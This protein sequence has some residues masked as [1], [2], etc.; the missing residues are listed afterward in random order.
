MPLRAPISKIVRVVYSQA[1]AYAL[2]ELGNRKRNRNRS[3]RN[4]RGSVSDQKSIASPSLAQSL[5]KWLKSEHNGLNPSKM[6]QIW[7]KKP[8]SGLRSLILAY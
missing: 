5:A 4:V 2:K 1:E 8:N 6:A 3:R 7:P